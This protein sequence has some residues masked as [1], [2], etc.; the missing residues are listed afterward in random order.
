M[1]L[2][3]MTS[4]LIGL[5]QDYGW[6]HDRE[7][8]GTESIPAEVHARR[9]SWDGHED[10][11]PVADI[12]RLSQDIERWTR[13]DPEQIRQRLFEAG[14]KPNMVGL[15]ITDK[16]ILSAVRRTAQCSCQQDDAADQGDRA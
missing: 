2:S 13:S 15:P 14:W 8:M 9:S 6:R 3:R 11:D 5:C 7:S 10:C 4:F 16:T 12:A 1:A